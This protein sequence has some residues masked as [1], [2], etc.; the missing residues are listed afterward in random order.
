M[1]KG[2]KSVF[3]CQ[4]CGYESPKWL[5]QCPGCR[6]WN[7]F[8]EET[9]SSNAGRLTQ[10]ISSVK[11]K[12]VL[13]SEIEINEDNRVC[14]GMAELDRVLG[15]GIVQGSMVLVGGDPGIGKSTLLLQVCKLLCD[16]EHKV[17]YVSGEESL[18]QIKMR[19]QRIGTF[20]DNLKLFCDTNLEQIRMVIEQEKPEAVII[21]SIQTISSITEE[22]TAH[23]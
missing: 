21:D 15:G 23:V 13:L 9:I 4:N 3:F 5:G 12:P 11:T 18:R 6:E 20:N 22:V 8:V 16:K 19:A 2:K 10:G 1:A 17:L 7:T 14:T